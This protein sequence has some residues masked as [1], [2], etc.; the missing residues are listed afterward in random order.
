MHANER[1]QPPSS[2]SI[3]CERRRVG[4]EAGKAI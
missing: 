4:E 1:E 2:V 3:L